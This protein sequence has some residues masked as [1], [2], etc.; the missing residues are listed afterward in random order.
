M[1]EITL[2]GTIVV[3]QGRDLSTSEFI[4]Q[5]E[6]TQSERA[7]FAEGRGETP[8]AALQVALTAIVN[9]MIVS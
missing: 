6:F 2:S 4:A 7:L 3:T 9:A 5:V 8:E 1:L